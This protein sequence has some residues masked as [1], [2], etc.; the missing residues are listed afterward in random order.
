MLK[1]CYGGGGGGGESKK[2]R[3][4]Q[5]TFSNTGGSHNFWSVPKPKETS[6][7][8]EPRYKTLCVLV[9]YNFLGFS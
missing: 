9:F 7:V 1:A 5:K 2:G 8:L 3:G 6:L 4:E